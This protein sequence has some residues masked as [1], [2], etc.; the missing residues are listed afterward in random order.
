VSFV[1]RIIEPRLLARGPT[2]VPT[3]DGLVIEPMRRRHLR[4]IMEI[5]HQVYPKPWTVGVFHSELD[6]MR[7]GYRHYVI[8]RSRRR[9]GGY[10]GLLLTG[11]EAHITNIAVDPAFHRQKIG[12][13]LLLHQARV[14]RDRGFGALTLEVRV[15]NRAAQELYRQFGFA[16]AGIRKRY[17]ED[18]EDAIV[19]W[20]HDIDGQAYADRLRSIEEALDARTETQ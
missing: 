11:D 3:I 7:D 15:S 9:L 14:A 18:V 17:Y 4:E 5:E 13:R 20:C 10:A 1:S 6:Q 19:M 2:R 8:A 16:P 12:S